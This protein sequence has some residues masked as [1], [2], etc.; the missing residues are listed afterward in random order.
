[1]QVGSNAPSATGPRMHRRMILGL[2]LTLAA[3]TS[4]AATGIA[5]T[6]MGG[7]T[8]VYANDAARAL[9]RN[10]FVDSSGVVIT[11]PLRTFRESAVLLR[12][13]GSYP[14]GTWQHMRR[15]IDCVNARTQVLAISVVAPSGTILS[16][17]AT[18]GPVQAVHWDTPEGKV[19]R[20]VCTGI[21]PR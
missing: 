8:Q 20:Y 5:A 12:A 10:I 18:A 1:M 19:A 9:G 2:A 16:S 3:L 17:V 4:G 21:L 11:G 13:R 15:K 14:A 6:T 7:W